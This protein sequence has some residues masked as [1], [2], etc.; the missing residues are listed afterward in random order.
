MPRFNYLTALACEDIRREDNGKLIVVG[1]FAS[2]IQFASF[3]AV[4]V[5]A[6]LV[7]A[8]AAEMGER[9]TKFQ[10]LLDDAPIAQGSAAYAPDRPGRQLLRT[11]AI[12]IRFEKPSLLTFQVVDADAAGNPLGDWVTLLTLPIELPVNRPAGR[13]G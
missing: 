10:L 1:A 2:N 7:V 3:P 9:H 12:D 5:L 6:F 4:A 8:E 11:P 13:S